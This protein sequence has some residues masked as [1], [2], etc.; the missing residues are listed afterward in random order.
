L[1]GNWRLLATGGGV[2]IILLILPGGLAGGI[3]QLRDAALTR[4]ATRR[5]I[6]A[7]GYTEDRLE[8]APGSGS[9][10]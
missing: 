6:E 3:Y 9:S 10:A 1:S 2:L 7:P 8:D 4:L 5:G